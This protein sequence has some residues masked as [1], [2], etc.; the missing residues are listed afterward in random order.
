MPEKLKEAQ[1]SAAQVGALTRSCT[2]HL[3]SCS[4]CITDAS[5]LTCMTPC[6]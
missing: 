2:A 3:C 6:R 5:T 4:G 1:C